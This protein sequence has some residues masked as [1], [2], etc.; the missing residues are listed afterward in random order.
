MLDLSLRSI[1][2]ISVA[3]SDYQLFDLKNVLFGNTTIIFQGV[4][5]LCGYLRSSIS[6]ITQATT[7]FNRNSIKYTFLRAHEE[8]EDSAECVEIVLDHSK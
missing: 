1:N 5:I 4:L 7:K 8:S 6:G 3:K 2:V